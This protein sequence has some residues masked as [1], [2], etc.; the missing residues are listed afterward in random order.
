MFRAKSKVGVAAFLIGCLLSFLGCDKIPFVSKF[1][2]SAKTVK[3]EQ[4]QE[5]V[6]PADTGLPVGAL[7]RVGKWTLTLNE[8]NDRLN[9]LKE[10]APDYDTTT[11]DSKKRILDELI[12]QELLVQEAEATG[13][14]DKKDIVDAVSEFRRTLLVREMATSITQNIESAENEAQDYYNQN[15]DLFKEPAEWRLREIVVPTE[16]EAKDVLVE[17]LKGA[18]FTATAQVRSKSASASKGGDLGFISE[19]KFPQMESAVNVLDVGKISS[20]VKGP[21][22]YYIFKLEEKK[23]GQA[24]P[25][26][27]IAEQLKNAMT[28]YKQQQEVMSHIEKLKEK[29][30]IETNEDLLRE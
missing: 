5:L 9:S 21:G 8:F 3:K 22:G 11:S 6:L 12:N 25:Y 13:V 26:A 1:F 28:L 27:E 23:G 18:D 10:L 20:V 16:S 4:K 14:A 17:L 19:F 15:K 24:Q 2:P 29:T 7:A 30:K